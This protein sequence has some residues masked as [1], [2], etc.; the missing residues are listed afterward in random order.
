MV[1]K[2]GEY[3]DSQTSFYAQATQGCEAIEPNSAYT[4]RQEVPLLRVRDHRERGKTSLSWL[5]S[6]HTFSFGHYYD[7]EFM[8][9]GPIRVINDDRVSPGG[10]FGA[11]P[12]RDMEIIS[13]VVQGA[14]EH[15]DSMG[16]GAVIRA[17]EIQIMSAGDGITHSEFNH[18]QQQPVRFLQ[19]WVVPRAVGLSPSYQQA[20]IGSSPNRLVHLVGPSESGALVQINSDVDLFGSTQASGDALKVHLGQNRRAWLQVVR[21]S[22]RIGPMIC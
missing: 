10:G 17:G 2:A 15:R 16:H 19:M 12:H 22:L 8:G 14:L 1:A 21:G 6:R 4:W 7:P 11:H 18:S 13:Y 20:P 5:D 3:W 9:F